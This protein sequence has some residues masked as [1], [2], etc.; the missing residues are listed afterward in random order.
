MHRFNDLPF[1][2]RPADLPTRR[3]NLP[4]DQSAVPAKQRVR[5]DKRRDG[6]EKRPS[7]R[8]GRRGQ[9]D[10]LGIG[11]VDFPPDP[12]AQDAIL[13]HDIIVPLNKVLIGS[14]GDPCA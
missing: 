12:A 13:G 8:L 2:R 5:R 14:P 4:F 3:R 9:R 1:R 11:E 6:F 10:A 7:K